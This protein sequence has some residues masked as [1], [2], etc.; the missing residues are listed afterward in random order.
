MSLGHWG[1]SPV[2]PEVEVIIKIQSDLPF[3]CQEII[4]TNPDS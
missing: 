3:V 1:I 2:H 4:P